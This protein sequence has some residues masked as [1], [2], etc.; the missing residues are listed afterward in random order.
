MP[1]NL[2]LGGRGGKTKT[3]SS[4]YSET[5]EIGTQIQKSSMH[6]LKGIEPGAVSTGRKIAE[7]VTGAVTT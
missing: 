5:D 4:V 3:G 2:L 6:I 7:A 1:T